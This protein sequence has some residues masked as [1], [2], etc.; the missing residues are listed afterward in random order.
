MKKECPQSEFFFSGKTASKYGQNYATSECKLMSCKVIQT[1]VQLMGEDAEDC[2]QKL[3]NTRENLENRY[4]AIFLGE[5]HLF[6]VTFKMQLLSGRRNG[7]G[8]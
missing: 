4:R 2:I 5:G 3:Q 8:L 6:V 1:E 7:R